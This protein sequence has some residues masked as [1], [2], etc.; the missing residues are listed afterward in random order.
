[1][2]PEFIE[3]RDAILPVHIERQKNPMARNNP[4]SNA[5]RPKVDRDDP[6]MALELSADPIR[7]IQNEF[8]RALVA[9]T[10]IN[11]ELY[12]DEHIDAMAVSA[13]NRRLIE[14]ADALKALPKQNNG[15][16]N[17][18]QKSAAELIEDAAGTYDPS[19]N[20]SVRDQAEAGMMTRASEGFEEE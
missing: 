18:N 11:R 4:P 20:Q 12:A 16:K 5:K 3:A 9:E 2:S 17:R 8:Q 1:M 7:F 13:S 6:R 14:L 10:L 15:A 19:R